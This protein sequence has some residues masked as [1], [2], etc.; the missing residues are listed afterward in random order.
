MVELP[1]AIALFLT[2]CPPGGTDVSRIARLL[3]DAAFRR[4]L[5][6]QSEAGLTTLRVRR[7]TFG[8]ERVAFILA[9]FHSAGIRGKLRKC[10]V[11]PD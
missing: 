7:V 3:G 4:D 11:S 9:W 5:S 8:E 1:P 2:E 10:V 6:E